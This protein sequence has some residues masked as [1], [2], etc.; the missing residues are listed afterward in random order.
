MRLQERGIAWVR[1]YADPVPFGELAG[2][3]ERPSDMAAPPTPL[4]D[5]DGCVWR[6]T[7][8]SPAAWVLGG[9]STSHAQACEMI[10]TLVSTLHRKRALILPGSP[11]LP[12]R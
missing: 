1:R 7:A 11:P 12:S 8:P 9:V 3:V 10:R 4:R 6:P 2:T 5:K